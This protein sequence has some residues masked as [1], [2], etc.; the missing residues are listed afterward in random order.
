MA[1]LA[2]V[3]RQH[4]VDTVGKWV[5]QSTALVPGIVAKSL[6]EAASNSALL[7]SPISGVTSISES[8]RLLGIGD[9]VLPGRCDGPVATTSGCAQQDLDSYPPADHHRSLQ[10]G[11]GK[12]TPLTVRLPR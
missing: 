9:R 8:K 10:R 5:G 2:R 12:V 6:R 3:P 11:A 1:V 7:R 4:V